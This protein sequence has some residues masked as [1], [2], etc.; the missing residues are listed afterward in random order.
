MTQGDLQF[1]TSLLTH[2]QRIISKANPSIEIGYG[3]NI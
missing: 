1:W 3:I 2:K